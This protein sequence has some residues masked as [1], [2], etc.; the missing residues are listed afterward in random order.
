MFFLRRVHG[1]TLR[2]HVRNC[3]TRKSL[4][5]Q[6]LLQIERSQLRWFDYVTKMPRKDC[7]GKSC[8]L[9]TCDSSPEI[10]QK[11]DTLSPSSAATVTKLP[12]GKADV[13]KNEMILKRC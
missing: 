8:W 13:N 9:H 11:P 7:R 10:D 6:P 2:D 5:V 1:V 3:E 4:N 12:G